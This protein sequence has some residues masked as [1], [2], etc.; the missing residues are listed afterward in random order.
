MS[1][2]LSINV[3]K[4]DKEYLVAGKT[5]KFLSLS[6]KKN[7]DGKD[8]YGNDG[9]IVQVIPKD[10]RKEGLRGPIVGNYKEF[11]DDYLPRNRPAKPNY[12]E[13]VDEDID[14]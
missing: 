3:T 4:I 9:F 1:T 5:G 6:L 14:F 11:E 12:E 13:V 7:K 10:K 2:Q 8:K